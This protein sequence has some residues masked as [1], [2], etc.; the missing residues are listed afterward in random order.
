MLEKRITGSY[1]KEIRPN[2]LI[3]GV[4]EK[5]EESREQLRGRSKVVFQE[6]NGNQGRN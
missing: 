5:A 2:L 6:G 4:I 1:L 3:Y